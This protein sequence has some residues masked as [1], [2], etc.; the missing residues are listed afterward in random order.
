V[1]L[2]AALPLA[3]ALAVALPGAASAAPAPPRSL[4]AKCIDTSG[5]DAQPFWLTA[6]DGTRLYAI[7]TGRGTTTVVLAHESPAD[8][9]GWL[10]YIPTLAAA[11]LR[12]LAFDFRNYGDSARPPVRAAT[13]YGRDLAAAVARARADGA[14]R[15]FLMGASFGGAAALTYGPALRLAGLISLSGE[16]RLDNM[17]ALRAVRRLRAPL[18]IVGS[19]H[20]RYASVREMLQLYRRAGSK[21]KR[22]AFYPGA[23][24][25][26][27]IVETAPY[28]A[29]ARALILS[30][31]RARS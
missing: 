15:V 24:H 23:F 8:L 4:A 1:S 2:S 26:W 30:W 22:T 6:S 9:C 25:G 17:N 5:V 29:R 27:S 10:P 3:A 20:D 18:L 19:R 14:G 28:A 12:V 16:A 21:D 13:A 11:G 31:I 7:E